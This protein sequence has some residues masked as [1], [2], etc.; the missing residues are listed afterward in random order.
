MICA[1][2]IILVVF[3]IS[4]NIDDFVKSKAPFWRIVVEYYFNMCLYFGNLLSS[5]IIFLTIIWF[6][7]KLAQKSEIVAILSGGVSYRRLLRPYFL[8]ASLLVANSLLLGHFI[9]P[10]SQSKKLDFELEFLK[11]AII[12]DDKNL[13]REIEP[14]VI[15]HFYQFVPANKGGSQF[16]LENWKEGRL[17][18]KLIAAGASYNE[19]KNR[20]TI[21]NAQVRKWDE[22]GRETVYFKQMID[23]I[24]PMDMNTFGLRPEV[25]GT[26]N[27]PELNAF[28]ERQKQ[29]GSGK[30]PQ[31]EIEKYNR[32]ASAFSIFILTL[33]GVSIASRK[34]RGGVGLHLFTA[35]VIGF[36]FIFISRF[37]A[38]SAMTAGLPA[39]LAVW[40]PN[41]IFL[42][43]GIFLYTRAQK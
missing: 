9:V 37:A 22:K 39:A 41:A 24:L 28:I 15:A 25:I 3:D 29:A 8:A 2:V 6:T 43:L 19:E 26:M 23:T 16:S 31:F 5:F 18:F 21:T 4:E 20:W 40:V 14:G 34:S 35:I 17:T 12:I 13:H 7:S 33:I 36:I 38:V 30:V 42:L 11:E 10:Y 1:F 32:T 27:W